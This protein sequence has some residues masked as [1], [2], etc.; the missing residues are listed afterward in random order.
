MFFGVA[1][2]RGVPVVKDWCSSVRNL[3]MIVGLR[4][5][6]KMQEAMEFAGSSVPA[7]RKSKSSRPRW[8]LLMWSFGS[9]AREERM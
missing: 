1:R 3:E 9:W 4:V 6:W 7:M 8:V 5:R 2:G